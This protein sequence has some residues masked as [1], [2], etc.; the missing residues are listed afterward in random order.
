MFMLYLFVPFVNLWYIVSV[1][2]KIIDYLFPR[3]D[4]VQKDK[5]K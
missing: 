4:C 3:Y 2:D 5:V 1:P